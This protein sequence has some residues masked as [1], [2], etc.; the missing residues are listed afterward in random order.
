MGGHMQRSL[1]RWKRFGKR[2]AQLGLLK[3]THKLTN[4]KRF[5]KCAAQQRITYITDMYE[6][7][8]V[9]KRWN[10]SA[11]KLCIW[12][13]SIHWENVFTLIDNRKITDF[14]H[15]IK[16]KN[17]ASLI[18]R[19][20]GVLLQTLIQLTTVWPL[21][22]KHIHTGKF[23]ELADLHMLWNLSSSKRKCFNIMQF[24]TC[25]KTNMC[26]GELKN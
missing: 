25:N 14:N 18:T 12:F 20:G 22:M 19:L 15:E 13:K 1:S 21:Q 17:F 8:K 5:W 10:C 7:R 26:W 6:I 24:A 11:S 3:G 16:S 4:W 9:P 2:A 23:T